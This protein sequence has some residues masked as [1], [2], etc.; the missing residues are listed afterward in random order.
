MAYVQSILNEVVL[1]FDKLKKVI[2]KHPDAFKLA[3]IKDDGYTLFTDLDLIEIPP[4][5][6]DSN[7]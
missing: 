4:N 5:E 7:P 2:D 3:Y 1:H 6:E